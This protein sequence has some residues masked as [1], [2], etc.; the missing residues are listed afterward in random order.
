MVTSKNTVTLFLMICS[1]MLLVALEF[2]WLKNSYEKAYL[3]FRMETSI[4]LKNT[5]SN[6]VDSLSIKITG[7]GSLDS[8][9]LK[10][11]LHLRHDSL[12]IFINGKDTMKVSEET[13]VSEPTH[14]LDSGITLTKSLASSLPKFDRRRTFIVRMGPDTLDLAAV[15]EDFKRN[16]RFAGIQSPFHIEPSL[17]RPLDRV[18]ERK[19]FDFRNSVDLEPPRPYSDTVI[20]DPARFMSPLLSYVAIFPGITTTIVKAISTQILFS[21]IL[22]VIIVTSFIVT[23]RSLRAQQRLNEL[24]NDFIS[25]V[26][27]ELKTPVAT[28]SVA[29][30][31]LKDFHALDDPERTKEYL[32]IAQNEL[33]RLSLM[34]DKILKI[35]TFETQGVDFIA[36]NVNLHSIVQQVLSSLKLV[37]EKN[38]LRVVYTPTGTNFELRG[39]EIHLTNVIYNLLDNALKYGNGQSKIDLNLTASDDHLDFSIRDYGI[40]IAKEYQQKIFEKFFRVPT[41]DVHDIKGYGLGLNYVAGVVQKHGGTIR[42]ESEIG[43]GSLFKIRLPITA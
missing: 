26:T 11:N 28:V 30:E 12:Y 41:G 14:R 37:F 5:V 8:T 13:I 23:H 38:N 4:L 35:S 7:P 39:S 6:L 10:R 24:K 27:H 32:S 1:V 19:Y 16:L 20:T 40:G 2:L 33:S 18:D 34:T 29:L 15:T 21:A 42:V 31:A 9:E 17:I 3:D 25:N 36:Q 22:T 43:K